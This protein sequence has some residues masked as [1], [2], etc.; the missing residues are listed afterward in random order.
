[1]NGTVRSALYTFQ[2]VDPPALQKKGEGSHRVAISPATPA[3]HLSVWLRALA[4]HVRRPA[5]L[6]K[7]PSVAPN[8]ARSYEQTWRLDSPASLYTPEFEEEEPSWEDAEWQ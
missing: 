7:L 2:R 5:S 3:M 1:M 4:G 8:G 6:A